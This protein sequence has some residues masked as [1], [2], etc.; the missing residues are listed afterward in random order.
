VTET[1]TVLVVSR[2]I[3]SK[4]MPAYTNRGKP[5]STERK[6][7]R[8]SALAEIVRHVLGRIASKDH[9]TTA[10]QVTSELIVLES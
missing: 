6:K 5:V 1:A 7:G 8:E 4:I 10:A 9:R 2:A 3:V